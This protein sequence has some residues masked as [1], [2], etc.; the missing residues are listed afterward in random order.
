MAEVHF[1]ISSNIPGFHKSYGVGGGDKKRGLLPP[2]STARSSAKKHTYAHTQHTI[3]A[4]IYTYSTHTY[5]M[6]NTHVYTSHRYQSTLTYTIHTISMYTQHTH[7]PHTHI[8]TPHISIH[9]TDTYIAPPH[10]H[11]K[12]SP[13]G[14]VRLYKDLVIHK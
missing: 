6:R 4:H 9:T 14:T 12:L 2:L 7:I 3:Y 5:N 11:T 13:S 1:V 8:Y 10:T